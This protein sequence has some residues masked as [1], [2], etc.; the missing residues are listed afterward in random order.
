[1]LMVV[2]DKKYNCHNFSEDNLIIMDNLQ[3]DSKGNGEW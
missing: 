2:M 3:R 1:M